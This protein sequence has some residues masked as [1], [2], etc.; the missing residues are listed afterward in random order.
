VDKEELGG[1]ALSICPLIIWTKVDEESLCRAKRL[2]ARCEASESAKSEVSTHQNKEQ[3]DEIRD[4]SNEQNDSVVY[5]PPTLEEWIEAMK[6]EN[7]RLVWSGKISGSSEVIKFYTGFPDYPT[8][9][10]FEKYVEPSASNLTYYS[11]MRDNSDSINVE[12][13][14]PYLGGKQKKFPGSN[15]GCRRTL[16]PIDELWLFLTRLRLGLFE[17]DLAF[18]FN[19]S[20]QVVSDIV[21]TWANFLY[22]MLGSLPIWPSKEQIK[23]YLPEV[24]KAE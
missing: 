13:Q 24:F 16:Q 22:L 4:R 7:E 8:L 11:Y 1:V 20:E 10:E 5:G 2:Q 18:R 17:R 15:V 12:N 14:F 23:Q 6:K 21:I 19:I 9:I 3:Q